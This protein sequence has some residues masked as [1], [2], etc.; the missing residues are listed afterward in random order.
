ML[1]LHTADTSQKSTPMGQLVQVTAG[2]GQRWETE[3]ESDLALGLEKLG[4]GSP[5]SVTWVRK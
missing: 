4:D 1:A 5:D 2:L 3:R